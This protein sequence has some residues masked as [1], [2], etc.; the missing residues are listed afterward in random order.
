MDSRFTHALIIDPEAGTERLGSL[1][2]AQGRV[3]EVTYDA[4]PGT[5]NAEV[6]DASGLCLAPGLVDMGVKNCEPGDRH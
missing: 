2:S 5:A 6:I 3:A 1:R 4:A